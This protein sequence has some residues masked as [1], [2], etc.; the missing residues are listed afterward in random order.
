[1]SQTQ[2][3]QKSDVKSSSYDILPSKPDKSTLDSFEL[4]IEDIS[5]FSLSSMDE[6]LESEDFSIEKIQKTINDCENKLGSKQFSTK[7]SDS[8]STDISLN[9]DVIDAI[10]SSMEYVFDSVQLSN[11]S[12][13]VDEQKGLNSQLSNKVKSDNTM[14]LNDKINLS[15]IDDCELTTSDFSEEFNS[16]KN[17]DNIGITKD[18]AVFSAN[19]VLT[20]FKT[21]NNKSVCINEESLLKAQNISEAL[22]NNEIIETLVMKAAKIENEKINPTLLKEDNE[23]FDIS[24]EDSFCLNSSDSIDNMKHIHKKIKLDNE[25][26]DI[27]H[28]DTL[29]QKSEGKYQYKSKDCKTSNY[30]ITEN[31]FTSVASEKICDVKEPMPNMVS[32][33]IRPTIKNKHTFVNRPMRMYNRPEKGH[34]SNENKYIEKMQKMYDHIKS[35]YFNQLDSWVLINFKWCWLEL[36]VNDK[37]CEDMIVIQERLESLMEKRKLKEFSIFR[38]IVEGDDIASKHMI[39]IVLKASDKC[40]SLFD[41]FYTLNAVIDTDIS[42]LIISQ[43]IKFGTFLRIVNA[44]LLCKTQSIF[45][46]SGNAFKLNFNSIGITN[47]TILGHQTKISFCKYLN[48]IKNTGGIISALE[49]MI[50]KIIDIKILVKVGNY[51]NTVNEKDLSKELDKIEQMI[52]NEKNTINYKPI[53]KKTAKVIA[54]DK[55]NNECL[56]TWLGCEEFNVNEIYR[57]FNVK[58]IDKSI[59]TH[60]G[61]IHNKSLFYRINE[62]G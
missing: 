25:N 1:M 55:F 38:R 24:L 28:G 5:V 15:Q 35:I 7:I 48:R 44:E 52:A 53:I 58:F 54:K 29:K 3:S 43:Q 6:I 11:S 32:E 4:S 31:I 23:N 57:F 42:R 47:P 45:D 20:G 60:L 16:E 26:I 12:T 34:V 30:R 50:I 27:Q 18:T 41:G 46:L 19:K 61:T 36:F 13:Y 51:I 62:F 37:I 33:N 14:C 21:G 49:L 10:S 39:V 8:F 59:G 22:E 40:L 9:S 2:A 17:I 56:L